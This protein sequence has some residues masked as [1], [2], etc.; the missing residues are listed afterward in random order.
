MKG[1]IY[2]RYSTELQTENSTEAQVN[3][4]LDYAKKNNIDILDI[5]SDEEKTGIYVKNR[6]RFQDLL[7]DAL[8]KKFD[9]VLIYDVTRGS[10]NVVDWFE[11]RQTM[12]QLDIQVISITERLGD[13]YDPN[14]FLT[15]LITVGMGQH[16]VL[17]TRLKTIEGKRTKA[18][19][20]LF[21]GGYA[22]LGYDIKDQKYVINDKEAVVVREIFRLYNQGTPLKKIIQKISKYNVVGKRGKPLVITSLYSILKN[23]RYTGTYVWMEYNEK[24]MHRYVGKKSN[25]PVIIE[26]IIPPIINEEEYNMAQERIK[27]RKVKGQNRSKNNY[28]LSNILKCGECGSNMF[29][30]TNMNQKHIKTQSYVCSGKRK[31]H[32]CTLSNVSKQLIEERVSKTVYEWLANLDVHKL[33]NTIAKDFNQRSDDKE[34]ISKLNKINKQIQNIT[35]AIKNGISYPELMR[36]YESL[37]TEKEALTQSLNN[38]CITADPKL[39]KF[40]I[41]NVLAKEIEMLNSN[42]ME[43]VV[44]RFVKEVTVYKDGTLDI[45]IGLPRMISNVP[46]VNDNGCGG[47]I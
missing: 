29:G 17:Q 25:N 45:I 8:L 27:N 41:E 2:T 31:Y 34:K 43:S 22:P 23:I 14:N 37:R 26:N 35:E 1:V 28:L 18:K 21:L 30:V 44:K 5:Y 15:E 3:A 24:Q 32:I 40:N 7:N 4:C 6:F 13:I 39:L 47:K 19:H 20:G 9:C 42:D 33:S 12:K 36:E 16:F 10:R 46:V 11:F 38:N